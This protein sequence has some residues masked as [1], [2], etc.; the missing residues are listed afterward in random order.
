VLDQLVEEWHA[1]TRQLKEADQRL[2]A[3]ARE[4]PVQEAEAREILDT[5]PCVGP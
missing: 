1:Y 5:I 2:A 3:F 4:A